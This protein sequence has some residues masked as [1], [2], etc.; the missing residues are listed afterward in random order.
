MILKTLY[1]HNFRLFEKTQVIPFSD[2]VNFFFG[3][4]A[5]G[6]TTILEAIYL[7]STGRSFR[8]NNLFDLIKEDENYF[9]IEAEF[10]KDN[11]SSTISF[12]LDKSKKTKKLKI[13]KTSHNSLNALLGNLLSVISS[14]GDFSIINGSPSYRRRFLNLFISQ[15][16]KNYLFHLARYSKALKQRNQLLKDKNLTTINVWEKELAFSAAYITLKRSEILKKLSIMTQNNLKKISNKEKFLSIKYLPTINMLEDSLKNDTGSLASTL[17][18]KYLYQFEK[19]REKELILKSTIT[20]PHRDD[21]SFSLDDR[22]AKDFASEG[23]KKSI[24]TSLKLA[25]FNQLKTISNQTPIMCFD[26]YDTF[27]DS[28]R[29]ELLNKQISNNSQVFLS[30]T[31]L[32]SSSLDSKNLENKYFEIHNGII[33]EKANLFSN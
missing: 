11:I 7:L 21:F 28:S 25:E 19:N 6:K 18:N 5:Q 2:G 17:E 10:E 33:L 31:N 24:L 27:L 12:Y 23:Q 26:D 15:H 13:N 1:L 30:S 4:N 9:F 16:D 32:D 20:G 3:K 8:T 29:K 22:E 14:P